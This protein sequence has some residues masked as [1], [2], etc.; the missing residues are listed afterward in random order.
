[1]W[2]V[3]PFERSTMWSTSIRRIVLVL[4]APNGHL[5]DQ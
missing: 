5:P 1:M 2:F 4:S 3:F